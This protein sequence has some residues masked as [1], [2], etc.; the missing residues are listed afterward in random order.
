MPHAR[1]RKVLW[2]KAWPWHRLLCHGWPSFRLWW[3][4]K[5]GLEDGHQPEGCRCGSTQG[6]HSITYRECWCPILG[7]QMEEASLLKASPTRTAG[8]ETWPSSR[9]ALAGFVIVCHQGGSEAPYLWVT[10]GCLSVY[11]CRTP[12][13]VLANHQHPTRGTQRGAGGWQPSCPACAGRVR[14]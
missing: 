9:R 1:A 7:A 4:S 6:T 11:G 3:H 10:H 8:S 5:V 2:R 14:G 12:A 13:T